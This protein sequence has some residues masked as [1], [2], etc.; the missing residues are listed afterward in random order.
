MHTTRLAR[1]SLAAALLLTSAF[2]I[3]CDGGKPTGSVSGTVK[4]RGALLTE[5][6]VNFLGKNGS[7]GVA[8]ID[9]SG[10]FKIDG[11]LEADEYRVYF[12]SPPPEPVAPG[13]KPAKAK[14]DLPAKFK[15]P[16]TSGVVVPIK[17]GKNELTL[18]FKD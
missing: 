4:Y 2:A 8:K 6:D 7:A 15:D 16:A 3:G 9:G 10:S 11:S 17:S 14:A 12:S 18:E 13:A 1:R 5:G